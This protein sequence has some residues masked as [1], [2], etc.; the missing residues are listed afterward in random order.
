MSL[1]IDSNRVWQNLMR[2][3]EFRDAAYPGWT[4]RPFTTEYQAARGWL[5]DLMGSA[6]LEV[7]LD[8]GANLVGSH[9]GSVPAQLV[10]GSHTDTVI[11]AG[12]FDGMLGVIAAIECARVLHDAGWPLRH[13]LQVYDFL[14][15]E[16]SP[17]GVSTVGSRAVSGHLPANLLSLEDSRGETLADGIRRAGGDP[18]ALGR[19]LLTGEDVA[20][21]LEL[22]IE[23][24]PYLE[25]HKL[26]LGIVT[27]IV[28]IRRY[29]VT[30]HGSPGHAGATPMDTRRDALVGA[31]AVVTHVHQWASEQVGDLV[32]TIGQIEVQPNALNVIPGTATLGIEVRA[33]DG[34]RLD[35][36]ATFLENFVH[37]LGA[38]HNYEVSVRETTREDPV[39]MNAAVRRIMANVFQ[40]AEWAHVELPSW[41]GHDTVQMAHVTPHCGMIFVP[42][43]GGLSH[44]PEEWTE[45][46]DAAM[47]VEALLQTILQLD[48]ELN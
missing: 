32:A 38:E 14:A 7:T 31:S 30:I 24:G 48:R 21:Y 25:T 47:G 12:R 34:M 4:R 39:L 26:P 46:R 8:P 1:H 36:F 35:R 6:G 45:P 9:A 3:A 11:G 15:E 16:P 28:G 27:G 5:Q 22:H 40:E 2:L 20:A 29:R 41:A 17:Y 42:S 18:S 23:Q 13:G 37:G 33:L 10:V 43:R 19:P 44:C